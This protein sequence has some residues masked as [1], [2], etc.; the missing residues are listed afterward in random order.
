MRSDKCRRS[1][2]VPNEK[3]GKSIS[4]LEEAEED[5]GSEGHLAT[6]TRILVILLAT[7]TQSVC[8]L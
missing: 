1:V 5:E 6:H 8:A 7:V 3:D 2:L 4:L